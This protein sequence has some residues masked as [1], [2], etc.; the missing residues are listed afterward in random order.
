[1]AEGDSLQAS[2]KKAFCLLGQG[3]VACW[4]KGRSPAHCTS[5]TGEVGCKEN[6]ADANG[7]R[8]QS[9]KAMGQ[10]V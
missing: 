9:V 2:Y 6:V 10:A 5:R 1:M 8:R 3:Q 7:R 4:V